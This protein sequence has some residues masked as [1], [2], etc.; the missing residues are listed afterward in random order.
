M[1]N[2][3]A[4]PAAEMPEPQEGPYTNSLTAFPESEAY[5]R[6][7]LADIAL[8]TAPF[9][10]K[11]SRCSACKGMCCYHGAHVNDE[12]AA[13]VQAVADQERD[14]FESLGLELP[15]EVIIEGVWRGEPSGK[16]TALKPWDYR[17]RLPWFPAHWDNTACVFLTREGFCGLQLYS[18][19]CDRHKWFAKPFTC[20]LHPITFPEDGGMTVYGPEDDPTIYD[21]YPGFNT[22]THC[23]RP[24]L[25]GQPAYEV[26]R[27][28]LDFLGQIVGRDFHTEL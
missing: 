25:N 24:D 6:E 21:D 18:N 16:K 14:Y 9:A 19:D 26:L 5:L 3:T 17:E 1:P 8:E 12:E 27:D 22:V 7:N 2:D 13:F 20:W 15:E 28:E 4:T 10:R 11:I 23:G